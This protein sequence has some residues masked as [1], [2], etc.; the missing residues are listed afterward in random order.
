MSIV[1]NIVLTKPQRKE[2]EPEEMDLY[3]WRRHRR[4]KYE[5]TIDII[6][7]IIKEN[8][9]KKLS[10]NAETVDISEGG[11]GV[12][13]DVPLELGFVRFKD[14]KEQK[15]GMVM[16][17]KKLDNNKYRIGIQF[18]QLFNAGSFGYVGART[19]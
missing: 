13:T 6:V 16:W 9:I 11:I 19:A 17:N 10:L 18:D 8:K 12:V 14:K 1:K 2:K 3:E 15:S 7:N 5:S 4:E